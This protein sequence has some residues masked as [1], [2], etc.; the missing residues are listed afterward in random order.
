M[1]DS[2]RKAVL[3]AALSNVDEGVLELKYLI[4]I[5]EHAMDRLTDIGWAIKAS[6]EMA[7]SY[8]KTLKMFTPNIEV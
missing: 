2:V 4:S 5:G 6:Q 3:A 1:K 7:D 8:F